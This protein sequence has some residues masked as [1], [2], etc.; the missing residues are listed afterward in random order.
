[1]FLD[2]VYIIVL[3][4]AVIKGYR[5]GIIV[6]IF[7]LLAFVIGLAAALKLSATVAIWLQGHSSINSKWLPFLAFVIVLVSVIFIVKLA[8]KAI[9]EVV[10]ALLLGWADKLGGAILYVFIYTLIY[11]VILFY[12]TNIHLI[13]DNMIE[14]SQTYGFVEP[15]GPK[16]IGRI[17][18]WLPWFKDMFKE[19]EN[20]FQPKA[21]VQ[22]YTNVIFFNNYQIL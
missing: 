12:A 22:N 3:L 5:K 20:F 10:K 11:S 14:S 18:E 1:M 19:L 16:V 15:L 17:G 9:H 7:S 4:L 21:N 13:N 6:G 8:A 2:I